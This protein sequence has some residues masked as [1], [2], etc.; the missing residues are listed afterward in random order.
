[1]ADYIASGEER[2]LPLSDMFASE[3]FKR[4]YES[5]DLI[6]DLQKLMHYNIRFYE[7]FFKNS[8][9]F[10]NLAKKSIKETLDIFPAHI[11]KEGSFEASSLPKNI[12]NFKIIGFPD[13]LRIPISRLRSEDVG[14]IIMVRGIL[15]RVSQSTSKISS[16]KFE[17]P[18]C[19][20]FIS[21]LQEK[22][23]VTVPA[24]C[25]CGRKS[26]FIKVLEDLES[27]QE[28]E[29]EENLEEVGSRQPQGIKLY[30]HGGLTDP[31]FNKFQVGNKVEV[32][33][34]L[35]K[36]P[37]YLTRQDKDKII[38]EYMIEVIGMVGL[39]GT[40]ENL[41]ISEEE[42][43]EF[44]EIACN[45]PLEYLANQIAPTISGLEDIKKATVLFLAKGVTKVIQNA[46]R[47]RGEIHVLIVGEAGL[48]KSAL[49]QNIKKRA[50][51]C[52]MADGKATSRAGLV[53]S[54]Q[55]D[56]TTER[57]I[58]EAGDL[59]L[60]NQGY[61]LLD[62][63]EKMGP[64]DM[65]AIHRPLEQGEAEVS[66][67]GIHATLA[68]NTS[69][70]AV[71]NPKLG[72]F[73]QTQPVLNQID[74]SPTLL[75]RFDLIFIL[76]DTPEYEEDTK[77]ARQILGVH[78][79]ELKPEV[80]SDLI[81]KYF[82]Y[83][84]KIKPKI[85]KEISE[86]IVAIFP[87]IRS[88]SMVNNLKVGLPITPRHLEGL[89]RLSEASA[90]IRMSEFVEQQ[91]V[92]IAQ[93]LFMKSIE[94]FGYDEN[95]NYSDLGKITHKAMPSKKD[96]YYL[97]LDMIKDM[98]IKNIPVNKQEIIAQCQKKFGMNYG[99][100][101]EIIEALHANSDIYEPTRDVYDL[102]EKNK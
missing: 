48:A 43:R 66:K 64:E 9:E 91:D 19:G 35:K 17:C 58:L 98:K 86:K 32:I 88:F 56:K 55:K 3:V 44:R 95:S 100:I 14:R 21:I 63:A 77:K 92:D 96:K 72:A 12:I 70:F 28:M 97:V 53:W 24:K 5:G 73:S 2:I 90:K 69:L 82:A 61:L 13:S 79:G 16:I 20:T 27:M 4:D 89:I 6:L 75:S 8:D 7:D 71:A 60:A 80:K 26:N 41:V 34:I 10:I 99:E 94:Q 46:E 31:D 47:R 42:E 57:W 102:T 83:I 18:S 65:K 37:Q 49:L 29:I 22:N 36:L 50:V 25:S 87:R 30:L 1:M 51:N 45:H 101:Y 62:E 74:F 85:T 68:C 33:G 52:R 78:M 40:M 81:K 59:V 23:T 54:L 76:R 38:L 39:E 67:A 93:E 11:R 84:S 15:K